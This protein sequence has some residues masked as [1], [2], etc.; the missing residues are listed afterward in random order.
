MG[1]LKL[2]PWEILRTQPSS[3][4]GVEEDQNQFPQLISK[5]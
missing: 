4:I 1:S 2:K 5:L 3:K